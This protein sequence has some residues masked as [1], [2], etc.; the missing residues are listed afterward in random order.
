MKRLLL[1]VP[2]L[3]LALVACGGSDVQD[4]GAGSAGTPATT[5]SATELTVT[6]WADPSTS[7]APTVT[8][9]TAARGGTSRRR[10]RDRRA[11]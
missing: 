2:F 10:P 5:A 6:V 7:A 8:T 4:P 1:L 3:A 11:R 9:V